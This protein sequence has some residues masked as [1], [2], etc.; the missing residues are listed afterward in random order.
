MKKISAMILSLVMC[1]AMLASCGS[2]DSSEEKSSKVAKDSTAASDVEST[3][4]TEDES[5]AE[6]T[7][8][9]KDE[10]GDES[11]ESQ[12]DGGNAADSQDDGGNTA[13]S[14][15]AG[16]FTKALLE[17]FNS[18]VYDI[19]GTVSTSLTGESPVIIATDGNNNFHAVMSLFGMNVNMYILDGKAYNVIPAAEMYAVA[20]GEIKSIEDL[21]INIGSFLPTEATFVETTEEDGMTVEKYKT[22][23]EGSETFT[24]LYFDADGN[25]KKAVSSGDSGESTLAIDKLEFD[26]VKIELPD[27]TGWDQFED[28]GSLSEAE[29]LRMQLGMLGITKAMVEASGT[30]YEDL[31]ALSE[32][33]QQAAIKKLAE[34]NNIDLGLYALAL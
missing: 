11:A 10:G 9:S 23:D 20:E 27:M 30:T 7:G 12:D 26:N 2:D 8:E 29:K 34:D 3:E 28:E 31:A 14:G 32:D 19:E 17:K 4:G 24:S 16:E 5:T 22:G 18:G 13:P 21:G 33:D 6:D 1:A 25:L 15:E